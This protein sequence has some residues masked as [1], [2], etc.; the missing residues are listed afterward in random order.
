MIGAVLL[1]VLP[2]FGAFLLPLL[3]RH[4][5]PV[6]YWAGPVVLISNLVIALGLWYGVSEVGPQSIIFGGFAAPLG[7][8]FYIDTLAILFVMMLNAGCL[9]LWLGAWHRRLHEE[10]L[11]LLVTGAGCGLMMSGDLFNLYVFFEIMAVASYGLAASRRHGPDSHAASLRFLLLGAT[12]SSLGLLGIALIYALTGTLNLSHLA[13]LAPNTLHGPVGLAAFALLLIGFGVK[14]ELFP[15]NTW[16]QEVYATSPPRI[17]ALLAGI[18][19]KLALVVVLRLLLLLYS[20]TSAHLLLLTVGLLGLVSA[21]LAAWRATDLRRVLAYSSVGQLSLMAIAFSIPGPAGVMA[22][23]AL[24]LHHALVKPALF[25]LT[26]SWQARLHE[27]RG[28]AWLC[29][30]SAFAFVLLALSLIGVPPLPGFWAKF[31]LLQAG[32]AAGGWYQTALWIVLLSVIIETAYLLRITRLLF[33]RQAS[34]LFCEPPQ[35]RN[36]APV[37][38]LGGVLMLVTLSMAPIGDGLRRIAQ[39]TVD[40]GTYIN[41]TLSAWQDDKSHWNSFLTRRL[42]P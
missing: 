41:Y 24:G 28:L 39:Q 34:P 7:I 12:A 27:L 25:L 15:L 32:F 38:L 40:T 4:Y 1:V 18:V 2:F 26:E 23:I 42:T 31:W 9:V 33:A 29:Q 10:I 35:R 21:E 30:R 6:T 20:D 36:L 5:P 8:T 37:L 11:T 17:S 3:H 13:I 14:A 22:G 19:S 16:V